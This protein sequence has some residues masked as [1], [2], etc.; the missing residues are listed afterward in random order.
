MKLKYLLGMLFFAATLSFAQEYPLVTIQ[1]IQYLPD[2]VIAQGDAPSPLQGDT[3]RVRGVIM[4]A[5][6]VDPIG[7][8]RRIIA[9]GGRWAAYI[10]DANGQ[11][12]GGLYPIQHDTTGANQQTFFYLAD[13]AQVVEFTGVVNEFSGNT[14][15]LD[16]LLNP[17][18][19]IQIIET[20]PKRPD[21]LELSMTEF[22][23]NGQLVKQGEKYEGMY[24]VIRNTISSDRNASSGTFK[25]ND[26]QGNSMFMYDQSGYFTNRAH[27]LTGITDYQ[28]PQDGTPINFIRGTIHTRADGYYIVPLYPGDIYITATP[29]IISN[30]KRNITLVNSNQAVEI[31]AKILDL[32]G[33]PQSAQVKYRVNGGARVSVNMTKSSTDT[34]LW[35]ATIPGVSA[36]SAIV[37]FYL[38]ATDNNGLSSINPSDTVK[39]N[40]FYLV[41]NRPI[42]IADV[43][44]SPF[45]SGFSGFNG[46][47]VT[48]S[49]IVTA[50][51]SDLPGLGSTPP[52]VYMQ[53]GSGPWSGIML[54]GSK[55]SVM[56]S[57]EL[58][59]GD[60]VTITGVINEN[61]NV[62]QIDS[63]A[64]ITVNSTNNNLPAASE[65]QTGT[66]GTKAGGVLDAEQ[67]ESV[68]ISYK[69]ISVTDE[70]ADG[71][72]SHFGEM[73]VSDNSGNTR[74]ELQ[75]GAHKYH[76]S[77]D[78]NMLDNPLFVRITDGVTMSE[79]KGI[80]YFSFSFYKLAPRKDDD[81]VGVVLDVE[82]DVN[83]SEFGITQNYPNP[84]NPST[85]IKYSLPKEEFVTLKVYNV[86]GQEIRTLFQ[87]FQK[88]GKHSITFNAAQLPSGIYFYTIQA[89]EFSQVKKMMLMK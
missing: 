66:I 5:P 23:N 24:V 45:G 41:L 63:I 32:D 48:L 80:L 77:W 9:A 37:D 34:T 15:Q 71:P 51:T 26:G 36:D 87:G 40:Y 50:D 88:E 1:D 27:R 86:L 61:F 28:A 19:P 20:L 7:D 11:V 53:N 31:S 70:N 82:D 17:V 14:T 84:F 79:L 33:F 67:W 58:R 38:T 6:V 68:L 3:V 69:N 35:T 75:D 56:T 44:Y 12:W 73:F 60:N 2:S 85:M 62:T 21:P 47:Q 46:Y 52:R 42:T 57:F 13:T 55:P 29:P 49:G 10:Q 39:G 72:P 18:T 81:F 8:R 59:R 78:P 89:G 54:G 83:P 64:S 76:N 25:I 65:V 43:Q 30:I 74:V 16:L 22:M 4:V